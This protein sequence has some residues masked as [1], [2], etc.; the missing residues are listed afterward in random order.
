MLARYAR[1]SQFD[2]LPPAVRHE[3]LRAFVN[4]IGCTAGGSRE[5]GVRLML[6]LLSKFNG[7]K[8]ATVVGRSGPDS[9]PGLAHRGVPPGRPFLQGTCPCS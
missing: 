6:E 1:T 5:E 2:A 3:G 9:R 7:A 4:W 8:E